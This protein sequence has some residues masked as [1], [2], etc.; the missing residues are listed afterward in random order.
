M[1]DK[2]AYTVKSDYILLHESTCVCDVHYLY[3]PLNASILRIYTIFC[4]ASV[5]RCM[6]I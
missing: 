4:T 6:F 3:I 5:K 2:K 1:M